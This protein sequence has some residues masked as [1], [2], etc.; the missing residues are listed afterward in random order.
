MSENTA[1]NASKKIPVRKI[2]FFVLLPCI[3]GILAYIYR[4]S[5]A[6][7]MGIYSECEIWN[8]T[9]TIDGRKLSYKTDRFNMEIATEAL[10]QEYRNSPQCSIYAVDLIQATL[11]TTDLLD[12]LRAVPCSSIGI[13]EA[14]VAGARFNGLRIHANEESVQHRVLLIHYGLVHYELKILNGESLV[15]TTKMR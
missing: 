3:A 4:D 5:L 11:Q 12:A 8:T 9:R 13:F 15:E 10:I 14:I 1:N 7:E 2:V 6:C